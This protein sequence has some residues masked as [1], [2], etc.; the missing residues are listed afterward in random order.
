MRFLKAT[1]TDGAT[2]LF[3]LAQVLTI[4]PNGEKVKILMGAGLWYLVI[5][6]SIEF[7]E[8][9]NELAAALKEGK[10]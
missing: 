7:I 1:R 2:E 3:N 5:A 6:N 9:P 10:Q 8:C 4:Q